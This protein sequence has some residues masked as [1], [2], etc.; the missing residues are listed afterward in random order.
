[1]GPRERD[2]ADTLFGPATQASEKPVAPLLQQQQQQL[3]AHVERERGI[4]IAV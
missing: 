2:E 3:V 4:H 1:M